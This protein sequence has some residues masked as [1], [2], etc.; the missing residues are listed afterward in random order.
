MEAVLGLLVNLGKFEI[1]PIGE[2][3]DVSCFIANEIF[4]FVVGC[5]I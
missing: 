4:G 1:V 3:E 5:F 2:V